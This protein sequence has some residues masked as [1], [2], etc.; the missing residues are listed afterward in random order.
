METIHKL[1]GRELDSDELNHALKSFAQGYRAPVVGAMHLTCADESE[2]E[3]V[4]SFQGTFVQSLLPNLK[5]A[6]Q[7]AFRLATL[8]AHY[9]WGAVR[10]A[11][12][13]YATP[14]TR[15]SFKVL[16][17]KVNSH[18]SVDKTP[19][20][21]VFGK[22]LRY[23]ARS[24]YCGAL[25]A[26]M[27]GGNQ[28][29]VP[30]LKEV[31]SSE[32]KDRLAIL[33]DPDRVN[34]QFR[35]LYAAA[36]MARLQA[37]NVVVDIQDHQPLTPT[38]YF[39]IPCINLNRRDRDTEILCG[40]YTSDRRD[41]S[42][43]DEYCGFG[44]DPSKFELSEEWGKLRLHEGGTPDV[45]PARDHRE[46]VRHEWERRYRDSAKRDQ[47]LDQ[48]FQEAVHEKAT[49]PQAKKI[50]LKTILRLL[51]DL[52]PISASLFLFAEG[53]VGVHNFI[54]AQRISKELA[55]DEDAKQ[56]LDNIHGQVDAMGPEKA[57]RIIALLARQYGSDAAKR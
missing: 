4:D 25:H 18:V 46:L 28:P 51:A 2:R 19:E 54:R 43:V 33:L 34:P 32:G 14:K 3:C 7:S 48:A 55:G 37:R 29:F 53:V 42:S 27:E 12:A 31:F 23:Q 13:H 8:G 41:E 39:V 38:L 17:V 26:M 44:D 49:S 1:V 40:V 9:E 52:N 57:Q 22:M 47:R 24:Q 10:I 45:R 21:L 36:V 16:A 20:G 6:H 50:L 56:I 35:A 5:L 11:E 15:D 30:R